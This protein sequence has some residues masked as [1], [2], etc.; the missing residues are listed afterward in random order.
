MEGKNETD[1]RRGLIKAAIADGGLLNGLNSSEV[2][3]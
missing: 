3:C 1:K 2:I